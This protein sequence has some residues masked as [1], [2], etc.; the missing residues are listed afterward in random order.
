MSNT[1]V[2]RRFQDLKAAGL[3]PVLAAG[4]SEASTPSG[5]MA[6]TPDFGSAAAS[7]ADIALKRATIKNVEK[8]NDKISAE[9]GLL[10]EQK[11]IATNGVLSS[12]Q[13][14]RIRKAQADK[15]E[16][17]KKPYEVGIKLLSSA[18]DVMKGQSSNSD[19]H[20]R[21]PTHP[22]YGKD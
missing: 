16:L 17:T 1:A 18:Q 9:T 4:G 21:K 14:V 20:G 10:E 11:R 12:A 15:E 19:A 7:A 2:Q 3:N 22:L 6:Q 13:D 8:Q 5:A